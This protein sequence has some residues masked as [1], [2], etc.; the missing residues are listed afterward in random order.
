M[1]RHQAAGVGVVISRRLVTYGHTHSAALRVFPGSGN[2]CK[3]G[4]PA[5]LR[6]EWFRTGAILEVEEG[7]K[8]RCRS[9]AMTHGGDIALGAITLGHFCGL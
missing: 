3:L 9:D 4:P 6:F 5:P 1:G 7:V 2:G 8:H